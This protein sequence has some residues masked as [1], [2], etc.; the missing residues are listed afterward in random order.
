VRTKPALIPIDL[1]LL[2][3]ITSVF[4]PTKAVTVKNSTQCKN[5]YHKE[6]FGLKSYVYRKTLIQHKR[7]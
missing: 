6:K 4:V 2:P 7:D 5:S 3:L 1:G